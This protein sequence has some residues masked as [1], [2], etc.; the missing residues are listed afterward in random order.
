MVV[1]G[2]IMNSEVVTVLKDDSI[3]HAAEKM[4]ANNI[5][6][7]IILENGSP[8]GIIT[9]RDIF[10]KVL[11]KRRD[12][13]ET[14]VDEIMTQDIITLRPSATLIAASG[15]MSMKKVKQLPIEDDG[16][17]IGIVT[18]T[19]IIKNIILLTK[20]EKTSINPENL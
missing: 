8:A 17:L 9:R 10:E 6:C 2:D 3:F 16:K 12:P 1:L 18:Q 7:L 4:A 11:L 5:S 20:S 15:I 13:D 19:D 14:R